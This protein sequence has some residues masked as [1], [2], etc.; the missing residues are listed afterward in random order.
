VEQRFS[1]ALR[2]RQESALAAEVPMGKPLRT[3]T[4]QGTYFIT[5]SCYMKQQLLQTDRMASL[6]VEVLHHYRIQENYLLHDFVVMPDHFH[7]LITPAAGITLERAMQLIK[8]GF[9]FRARQELGFKG[10]IWQNSFYD[11]RVRDW[12]EFQRF[13]E[14]IQQNPVKKGIGY[15]ARKI[16]LQLDWIERVS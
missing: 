4:P 3:I 9:S 15:G 2:N 13:R 7:L 11:R 16:C 6:F 1:A 14:Y 12:E 8:G 10:E 5:S